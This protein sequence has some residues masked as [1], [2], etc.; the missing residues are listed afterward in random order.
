MKKDDCGHEQ[1]L[2]HSCAMCNGCDKD[3]F[4]G[5]FCSGNNPCCDMRA[6]EGDC[7]CGICPVLLEKGISG[8][9]FCINDEK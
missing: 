5:L 2:C 8:R 1:C 6:S 3:K 7:V 4:E 9:F